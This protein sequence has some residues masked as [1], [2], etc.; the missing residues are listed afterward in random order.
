MKKI[1]ELYEM[2]RMIIKEQ[3][4]KNL[5]IRGGKGYGAGHPYQVKSEPK[6]VLGKVENE[7]QVETSNKPVKISKAF[8][9]E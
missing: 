3:D 7:E 6:P 1:K 4:K 8:K 2:I 5:N 9:K